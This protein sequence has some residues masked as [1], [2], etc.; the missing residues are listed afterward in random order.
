MQSIRYPTVSNSSR[1][2]QLTAKKRINLEISN[3]QLVNLSEIKDYFRS[4]NQFA[5]A[6][7]ER[8]CI[9]NR[10][11]RH[12]RFRRPFFFFFRVLNGRKNARMLFHPNDSSIR[13]TNTW[14]VF[15]LIFICFPLRCRL[16]IVHLTEWGVFVSVFFLF[17]SL[18]IFFRSFR[19]SRKETK[20]IEH[21]KV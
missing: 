6:S 20:L 10:Y 1:L 18:F 19:L 7:P 13:F 12:I 11:Y 14:S 17:F 3:Q 2:Y 21:T 8:K 4:H 15:R 9:L 16:F 5:S